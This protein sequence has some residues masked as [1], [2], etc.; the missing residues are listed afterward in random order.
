MPAARQ[1]EPVR[2]FLE[3][4]SAEVETAAAPGA[5]PGF[6]T[7][8]LVTAAGEGHRECRAAHVDHAGGRCREAEVLIAAVAGGDRDRDAGVVEV[9]VFSRL[10]QVLAF[11]APA[12]RD[13]GCAKPHGGVLGIVQVRTTA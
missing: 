8:P 12:V 7:R 13:L 2:R 11:S 4:L 6:L 10:A 1:R 5:A 9:F 3:A